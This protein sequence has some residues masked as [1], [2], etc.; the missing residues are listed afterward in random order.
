MEAMI[1]ADVQTI[2]KDELKEKMERGEDFELVNV[3][4]P[5]AHYLGF[6]KGSK[7]IPVHELEKR[8]HEL[9]KNKEIIVYCSDYQCTA[10]PAAAKKLATMGFNVKDYEGGIKEWR[11]AGLPMEGEPVAR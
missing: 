1:M 2:T 7:A 9:D 5:K 11:E 4:A 6:I 8:M 10:S 3:L